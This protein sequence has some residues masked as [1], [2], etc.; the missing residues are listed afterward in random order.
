MSELEVNR[1]Q[2]PIGSNMMESYHSLKHDS[3]TPWPTSPLACRT[4]SMDVHWLNTMTFSG[5]P[6][7]PP[8]TAPLVP[9]AEDRDPP[10][11]GKDDEEAPPP[12]W[13][14]GEGEALGVTAGVTGPRRLS[15][16]ARRASDL[17]LAASTVLRE[18]IRE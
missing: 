8:A 10:A 1:S 4:S 12:C 13:G 9:A 5:R 18:W 7:W 15:D 14:G 16:P 6:L 11:D 3:I 17:L 2:Y